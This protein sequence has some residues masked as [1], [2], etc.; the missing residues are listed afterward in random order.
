MVKITLAERRGF[1]FGVRRAIELAT[2]TA[3]KGTPTFSLGPLIHNPQEI[4]RLRT[5]GV[6][7]VGSLDEIPAGTVIIRSHGAAPEVLEQARARGL[8]VVD[9]TCP[10]V[11]NAQHQGTGCW[12]WAMPT[13]RR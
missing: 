10:L 3:E 12:W 11:K 5:L 6:E 2:R 1:C 7:V 13:T 8:E 9:A 4:G